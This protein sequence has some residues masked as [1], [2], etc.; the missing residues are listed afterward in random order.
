M[1]TESLTVPVRVDDQFA[2]GRLGVEAG[3]RVRLTLDLEGRDPVGAE[4]ADV[5]DALT[6]LRRQVE[7]AGGLLWVNGARRN[8][9]A[10]GMLRQARGGRLAYV[11][12]ERPSPEQPET[13]DVLVG[14]A[15]DADVV[16]CAEQQRWFAAY[17]GVP[18]Q[19]RSGRRPSPREVAEARDNPGAWVYVIAGGR[20]PDGEVPP[21]AIEGA[22]KVGPD[23][24]I[25]GDFVE[26]PRYRP[27]EQ[28]GS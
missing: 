5:L 8:V 6:E 1:T 4:G 26:N 17:R 12:P 20:D 14:A 25:V 28:A 2:V 23:G 11:L 24:V 15:P 18:E 9:H 27:A 21:E 3:E 19:A 16:S 7:D 22:W 10:S 13:T